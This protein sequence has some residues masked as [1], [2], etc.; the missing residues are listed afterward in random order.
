MKK[1]SIFFIVFF[2]SV[3]CNYGQAKD[4][5]LGAD[6]M[7]MRMNQQS[8]YFN[9]S[10]P[11]SVN[12][13]VNVWGWVKYPGRYK[14][15]I[16]TTAS[17]LLS[18]AGGPTDAADLTDLRIYRLAED[19]SQFLIKFNYNDLLYE[20]RLDTKHRKIPKLEA[21]D[22]LVVPGAPRMYFRDTFSIWISIISTLVSILTLT[23]LIIK[24]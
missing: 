6:V 14:V 7:S 8:G 16:Y 18:Y 10:D 11:E 4:Y 21:G 2:I 20:S 17:D 13:L 23:Y 9:L 15:P 19:S 5:E 3:V 12:I 1:C 24:K 22:V